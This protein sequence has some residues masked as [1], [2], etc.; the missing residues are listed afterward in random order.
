MAAGAIELVADELKDGDE[1]D[2]ST[3]LGGLISDAQE[4]AAAL[5]EKRDEK[6]AKKSK[7]SNKKTS[8]ASTKKTEDKK[9]VESTKKQPKK[10]TTAAERLAKKAEAKNSGKED[11]EMS[12]QSAAPVDNARLDALEKSVFFDICTVL[13]LFLLVQ[14]LPLL[15]PCF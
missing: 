5:K 13:T 12:S 2:G 1:E 14:I 3:G 9:K 10:K 6:S 7:A 4:G 15:Y 11:V 8:K